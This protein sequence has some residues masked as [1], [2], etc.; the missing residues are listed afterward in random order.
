MAESNER[1]VPHGFTFEKFELEYGTYEAPGYH[2][3]ASLMGRGEEYAFFRKFSSL[4][5]LNLMRYQ[6]ELLD[7]EEQYKV[8]IF[9]NEKG[10]KNLALATCFKELNASE[11]KQK[12]ILDKIRT[13]LCE[14]SR[15]GQSS[16]R[17]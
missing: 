10:S 8:A 9:T 4:N 11:S 16:A 3:L 2:T 1:S 12:E 7:L 14:Y 6:A 13:K 15:Y 5:M 17:S